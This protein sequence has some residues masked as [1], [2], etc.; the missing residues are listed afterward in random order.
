MAECIHCQERKLI[1]ERKKRFGL[2]WPLLVVVIVSSL[3]HYLGTGQLVDQQPP[4]TM[5]SSHSKLGWHTTSVSGFPV[6]PALPSIRPSISTL[7]WW[8]VLAKCNGASSG[9]SR[10]GYYV[11]VVYYVHVGQLPAGYLSGCPTNNSSA[12]IA[13]RQSL[14][15]PTIQ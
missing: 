1:K 7:P 10:S 15:Q 5:H 11:L 2:N 12:W 4:P 8:E 9:H 3:V 13:A 14:S 6:F